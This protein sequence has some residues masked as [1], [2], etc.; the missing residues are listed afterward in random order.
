MGCNC[1]NNSAF[2]ES[3][4]CSLLDTIHILVV[5]LAKLGLM[6]ILVNELYVNTVCLECSPYGY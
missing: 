5:Y 4:Y 2:I 6:Q 1:K 3:R